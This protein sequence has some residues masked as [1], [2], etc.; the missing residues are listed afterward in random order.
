MPTKVLEKSTKSLPFKEVKD[1]RD[2]DANEDTR[3]QRK[4]ESIAVPFDGKVAR[5][6]SQPSKKITP[7]TTSRMPR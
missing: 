2:D 4:I 3:G 7:T 1:K 5:Q 6:V